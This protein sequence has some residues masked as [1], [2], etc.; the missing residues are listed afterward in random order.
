MREFAR[1]AAVSA[2]TLLVVTMSLPARAQPPASPA[3]ILPPRPAPV[4]SAAPAPGPAAAPAPGPAAA[5]APV[6]AAAPVKPGAAAPD[7][8]E[9]TGDLFGPLPAR[10]M[11]V[12]AEVVPD[13]SPRWR[14]L[15]FGVTAGAAGVSLIAGLSFLVAE[16]QK[17]REFNAYVAPAGTDPD[18]C[19]AGTPNEGAPGCAEL[20]AEARRARVWSIVSFS[21][22]GAFAATALVLRL[23]YPDGSRS[24]AAGLRSSWPQLACAPSPGLGGAFCRATF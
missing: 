12:M 10:A 18:R 4:P 15:A 8:A 7:Q 1:L 19:T 3:P 20:L 16:S 11:P 2:V 22:A 14:R 23:T 24:T 17:V 9:D 21:F 6:P 13:N 5:P